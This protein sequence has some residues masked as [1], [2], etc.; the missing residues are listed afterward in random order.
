MAMTGKMY[1]DTKKGRLIEIGSFLELD[2][3]ASGEYYTEKINIARLNSGR[4]GIYHALR[5]LDRNT[6]YLP[7]YLCPDVK[8][9]LESRSI[10]IKYYNISKDFEPLLSQN[11]EESAILIVNYF[12]LFTKSKLIR[13]KDRF[14]NVIVDNC[15]AFFMPGLDG[16]YNIYSCRKFFGV[17]DGCYVVGPGAGA[18][19]YDYPYDQ[20]SETSAYLLKRIEKGCSELYQERMMNEE[21]IDHSG[22]LK[23]SNLTWSLMSSIDYDFILS[24]RRENFVYTCSLYAKINMIN[25]DQYS[26]VKTVPLF[27]PLVV[28]DKDLVEKLRINGIYTGRRWNHVIKEVPDVSF[29]AFLSS[30]MVPLPIDQRY[31]KDDMN[32]CFKIFCKVV[33][34]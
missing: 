30:Y 3:R 5:L 22:V 21:R 2:L 7:F 17:P 27:Y 26:D 25:P 6:I 24:R 14:R 31:N 29:E 16:C 19:N 13:I 34:Q 10:I 12:G 8:L 28:K 9:F 1:Y 32:Y 33:K 11:E 18:K 4:S 20:S 23:M 15:G